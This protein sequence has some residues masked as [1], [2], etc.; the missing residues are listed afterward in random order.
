MAS[1]NSD[2]ISVIALH[3]PLVDLFYFQSINTAWKKGLRAPTVWRARGA[4]GAGGAGAEIESFEGFVSRVREFPELLQSHLF[5]WA[6]VS[7]SELTNRRRR[8]PA[9]SRLTN[10]LLKFEKARS[11]W[12]GI[13]FGPVR[14]DST[15]NG[16]LEDFFIWRGHI[17]GPV[18]TPYEDGI[19]PVSIRFPDD[20]PFK[21]P[22]VVRNNLL[23]FRFA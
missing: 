17:S 16:T 11:E 3:L 19:F 13:D 1:L 14:R 8:F 20:Y 10:E 4:G 15:N 6:H 21:P 7:L 9:L 23:G 2:I 22:R 5:R 18:G 12:E